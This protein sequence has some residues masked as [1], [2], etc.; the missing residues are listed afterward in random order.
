MKNPGLLAGVFL[1]Y[2]SALI[3]EFA[4]ATVNDRWHRCDSL[5]ATTASPESPA[6][7]AGVDVMSVLGRRHHSAVLTCPVLR[8]F[9]YTLHFSGWDEAGPSFWLLF[10]TITF[11][12]Q[13]TVSVR[14]LI[15]DFV[16][17]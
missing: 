3:V 15:Y 12:S 2:D 5:L 1:V 9:L 14:G 16:F 11:R 17:S 4:R 8:S 6:V 13:L 7:L 10:S